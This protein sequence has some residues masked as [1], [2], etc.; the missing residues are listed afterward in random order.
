M[1][2]MARIGVKE[3]AEILVLADQAVRLPEKHLLKL[4]APSL[5]ETMK[6]I[7]IYLQWIALL[8]TPKWFLGT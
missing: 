8:W 1:R 2:E 4:V 6:P 5:T 3:L 7:L